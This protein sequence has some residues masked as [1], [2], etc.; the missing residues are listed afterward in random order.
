MPDDDV[1]ILRLLHSSYFLSSSFI[2]AQTHR[3]ERERKSRE[4]N[5]DWFSGLGYHGKGHGNESVETW[6]QS[7]RLEQDT[8]QGKKKKTFFLSDLI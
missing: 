4:K 1:H 5:G 8:L 7:Y 3:G 6:I 2:V